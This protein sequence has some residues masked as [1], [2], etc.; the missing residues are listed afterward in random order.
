MEEYKKGEHASWDLDQEIETWKKRDAM[1]AAGEEATD[2]EEDEE[3]STLAVGSPKQ[4]EM[5]VGPERVEPD[6]RAKEVAVDI[7]E[8]AASPEDITRD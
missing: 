1:L 6:T 2:E 4:V 3:E 7:E 5:G 8:Q